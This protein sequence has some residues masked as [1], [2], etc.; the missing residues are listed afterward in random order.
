MSALAAL[1]ADFQDYILGDGTGVAGPAPAADAAAAGADFGALFGRDAGAESGDVRPAIANAVRGQFGLDAM[2][3]LAIYRHA[4][5]ARLRE[6]LGAAYDKTWGYLGDDLFA[7]LANGYLQAHPSSLRNL[8]WYGAEFA[9][10]L[11][12]ELPEHPCV[13]ELAR[14]E[15]ALG[16]AFDAADTP[17]VV[18]ADVAGLAPQQWDDVV[19]QLHPSV[20]LLTLEWNTVALWQALGSGEEPPEAAARA[21]QDWLVWRHAEQPHFRSLDAGEALALRGIGRGERFGAVCAA[22]G[23]ARL[24]ALAGQLQTWLAQQVLSA[25]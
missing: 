21:P 8:R 25:G 11:A 2:A 18:A 7:E 13:A 10:H 14:L 5:R 22:A 16:L 20:R 1:Q 3:R 4:Y 15:W 6:A 19:F 17:A 9:A 23:A 12:R 24:A